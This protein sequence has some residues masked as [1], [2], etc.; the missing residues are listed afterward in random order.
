MH[1]WSWVI[2]GAVLLGAELA[3]VDAQFYLVF[4]GA[5]AIF[6]GLLGLGGLVLAPWLQWATFAAF[7]LLSLATFRRALY[8]KL[9]ANIPAF[10]IGPSGESVTVPEELAPGASCRLEYR[11]STWTAVNAGKHAIA[12]GG[13]ARI[14]RVDG[15]SLILREH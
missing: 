5:A 14:E 3:F 2:V 6:V 9:R 4:I 7:A 11:G 12:A 8:A 15:L 1:W 10:A 13:R